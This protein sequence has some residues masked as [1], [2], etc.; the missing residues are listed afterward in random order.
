MRLVVTRRRL[1]EWETAASTAARAAGSSGS[2]GLRRFVV[3]MVWSPVIAVAVGI[4]VLLWRRD[5]LS[6]AAPFLL[7]WLAARRW[8]TG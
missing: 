7:S 8:P 1:L 5:A 4:A 6:V 3:E 2:R